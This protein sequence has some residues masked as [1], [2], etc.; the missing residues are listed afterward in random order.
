[1]VE[2]VTDPSQRDVEGKHHEEGLNERSDDLKIPSDTVRTWIRDG[3]SI[4]P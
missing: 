4:Q 2:V 1:M 3:K